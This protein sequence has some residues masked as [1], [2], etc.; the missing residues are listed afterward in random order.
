MADRPGPLHDPEPS[1][2]GSDIEAA[3][4]NAEAGSPTD[5]VHHPA[6]PGETSADSRLEHMREVDTTSTDE[7]HHH[8]DIPAGPLPDEIGSG[9]AQ[10][11]L[12]AR[13]SDRVAGGAEPPDGP[14]FHHDQE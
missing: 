8:G 5:D 12:G 6:A 7:G 3:V 1:R 13:I 11:I 14:P 4:E 10:R 2:G 9:G